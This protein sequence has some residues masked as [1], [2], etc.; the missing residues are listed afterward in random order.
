M[1]DCIFC[2]IIKG[3]AKSWK[4]YET[5]HAYAFLDIHPASRYHTLVIPK[6]HYTNIFD[7]PE[8]ELNEVISLVKKVSKL[9]EEKLGLNN[10]QII[11]NSGAEAQQ[12]VFHLHFHIVPRRRGDGQNIKWSTHPEWVKDFDEMLEKIG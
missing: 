3:D 5:S 1:T 9:F 8:K 11:S 4:V 6:K 12:E 10:I 2:S 7:I